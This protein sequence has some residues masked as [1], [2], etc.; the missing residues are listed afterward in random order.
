MCADKQTAYK[1]ESKTIGKVCW[2]N[3][4]LINVSRK[5]FDFFFDWWLFAC[6]I[7]TTVRWCL[8]VLISFNLFSMTLYCFQLVQ[9]EQ[10]IIHIFINRISIIRTQFFLISLK[11]FFTIYGFYFYK[12]LNFYLSSI[13]L[14]QGTKL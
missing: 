6:E 7:C 10:N 12:F 1:C 14:W 5:R 13:N 9:K 8:S 2:Q 3:K 4:R 11:D